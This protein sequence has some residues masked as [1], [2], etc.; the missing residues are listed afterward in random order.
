MN[1]NVQQI[2]TQKAREANMKTVVENEK[3]ALNFKELFCYPDK[4]TKSLKREKKSE[5]HKTF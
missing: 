5:W 3:G 4:N 1:K 2:R